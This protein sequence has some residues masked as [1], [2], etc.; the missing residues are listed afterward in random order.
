ME[1]DALSMAFDGFDEFAPPD[2]L[3]RL[4]RTAYFRYSSVPTMLTPDGNTEPIQARFVAQALA[5]RGNL[6]AADEA[7]RLTAT[8]QGLSATHLARLVA[9]VRLESSDST[10]WRDADTRY[11]DLETAEDLSP[12]ERADVCFNRGVIAERL[13]DVNGAIDRYRAARSQ[14]PLLEMAESRLSA[15]GVSDPTS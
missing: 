8:R 13:G 9:D 1:W 11:A 4:W 10:A 7:L 14:N 12:L 6:D 2:A 15:L 3:Q 5:G